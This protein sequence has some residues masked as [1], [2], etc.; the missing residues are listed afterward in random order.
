MT[1][2]QEI[3]EYLEKRAS[4]GLP[5]IWEAPV[6]TLR[7]NLENR[8]NLSGEPEN[9]YEVEH[10][11][12]AG[13]T[14]E[15]PIRIYRPHWHKPL[16]AL[17]YF[18]GGGWVLNSL[19]IYEQALRSLANKGQFIVIA[20][21]YQKA[22]EHPF[23]IPF[24]DCYETLLWVRDRADSLG[25][26]INQIGVAGDSAGGNLAAAVSLK[27]RDTGDLKLAFQALIYPCLD[28]EMNYE[29]AKVNGTGYGL[30]TKSMQ[31]FWNLYLSKKTDLKDPYAS[32]VKAK[33]LSGVAPAI[34]IT[35]EFDPLLDDGYNYAQMLKRDGVQTIYYE[36]PG[37]IHGFFSLAGV[38]PVAIEAQQRLAD[39]INALLID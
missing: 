1:L 15:L 32:P 13:P 18:I 16:P 34:I 39:E 25:I 28:P 24:D 2:N 5:E 29:S 37:M 35:A 31:T 11:F 9:I 20:V 38:T 33:N 3:V 10:R 14:A 26:D 17:I 22:P 23:P 7:K 6:F 30:S 36:Y 4:S 12:I 27:A 19:D 8:P 21:N